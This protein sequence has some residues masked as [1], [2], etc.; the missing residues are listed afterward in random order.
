MAKIV[1]RNI[2]SLQPF[3]FLTSDEG[4]EKYQINFSGN[5]SN[6]KLKV[7]QLWEKIKYWE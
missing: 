2:E 3:A 4:V 5:F 1:M 7:K 6:Y